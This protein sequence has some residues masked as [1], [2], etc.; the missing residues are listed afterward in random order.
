MFSAYV[1][2]AP[3]PMPLQNESKL[4]DNWIKNETP[5]SKNIEVLIVFNDFLKQTNSGALVR[6]RTIPTEQP[7]LVGEV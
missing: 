7:P 4:S 5:P 2:N 1:I 6:L 3:T